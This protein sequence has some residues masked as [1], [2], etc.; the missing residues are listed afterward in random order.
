MGAGKIFVVKGDKELDELVETPYDK[1]VDLH[2]LIVDYP[3]IIPGD[4]INPGDPRRWLVVSKELGVPSETDGGDTFSLDIFFV[5]QDGVPTF[6]ECKRSSDTRI[7]RE[8][9]AQMLDYAA[10]GSVYWSPERLREET[11]KT[12]EGKGHALTEKVSGLLDSETPEDV[13]AFWDLVN[14]NLSDGNL[15][16]IFAADEIPRELKRIIEFLN[17]QM[18]KTEVLGVE[19]RQFRGAG[20]GMK[21]FAPQV[22]GLTEKARATKQSKR[23]RTTL[24]EFLDGCTPTAK[25]FFEDLFDRADEEGLVISWG[26]VG[27]SVRLYFPKTA[28]PETFLYGFPPDTFQVFLHGVFSLEPSE[29]KRIRR[30]L[31]EIGFAGT[32]DFTLGVNVTEKNI[33]IIKAEA[34]KMINFF[35]ALAEAGE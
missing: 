23:P 1:E 2:A 34:E 29:E 31:A 18:S 15:R 11:E 7:R 24:P 13:D 27:F 8:V 17:D 16:L 30:E 20:E 4:Q 19:V 28:K 14:D 25:R 5:D 9:V 12:A 6:I 10:N 3:E 32:G 26:R 33:E 22:V 35:K 21:V